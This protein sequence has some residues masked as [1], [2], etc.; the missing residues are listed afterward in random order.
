MK[1][2]VAAALLLSLTATVYC[3][4]FDYNCIIRESQNEATDVFNHCG[5][6]YSVC[7]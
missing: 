2:L 3:Q 4:S 1:N 7:S 5:S 6:A